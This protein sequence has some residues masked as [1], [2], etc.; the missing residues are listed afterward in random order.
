MR[1]VKRTTYEQILPNFREWHAVKWLHEC[2]QLECYVVIKPLARDVHMKLISASAW[3]HNHDSLQ[4]CIPPYLSPSLIPHILPSLSYS[5]PLSLTY[6]LPL[7]VSHT[8][9]L[10]VPLYLP[11]LSISLSPSPLSSLF[12]YI[13]VCTCGRID[14]PTFITHR[15]YEKWYL[16]IGKKTPFGADDIT[17]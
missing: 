14:N 11:P 15:I 17:S 4:R 7:F 10:L 6:S 8:I 2:L 9:P 5:L 3:I 12:L 16:I 1:Y 13:Y